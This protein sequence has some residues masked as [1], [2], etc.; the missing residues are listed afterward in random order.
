LLPEGSDGFLPSDPKKKVLVDK[1]IYRAS[2]IPNKN[3][4]DM[5]AGFQ[6][7]MGNILFPMTV[8]VFAS[9]PEIIDQNYIY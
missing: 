8:P 7:R 6:E 1:W 4:T 5:W 3:A 9:R 2:M